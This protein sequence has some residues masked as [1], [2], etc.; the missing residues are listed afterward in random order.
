VAAVTRYDGDR[1]VELR[2]RGWVIDYSGDD[3]RPPK[4]MRLTRGD[5]DIRLV[6][7][8]WQLPPP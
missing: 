7:D 5:L 6:I 3:E 4:R 1:L 8:E 2:Q